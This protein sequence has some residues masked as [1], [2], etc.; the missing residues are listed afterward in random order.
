MTE[1]D[2]AA[3]TNQRRKEQRETETSEQRRQ[4]RENEAA[5]QQTARSAPPPFPYS[6]SINEPQTV[7]TP[8]PP[9][10]EVPVPSISSITPSEAAI[11]DDDV[12]MQVVGE[13]F[14]A[15]S[16]I[17]FNGGDEPTTYESETQLSTTVKPSTASTPGSYPV[18]VKNGPAVSNAVD[19]TF[20]EAPASRSKKDK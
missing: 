2:N 8:L 7:S 4:A 15:D 1:R 10:V 5:N 20:N 9:D 3:E 14:F 12:V 16:V 19:F 11:G 6:A 18:T 17:T 13:N